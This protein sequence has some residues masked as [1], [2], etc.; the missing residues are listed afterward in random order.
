MSQFEIDIQCEVEVEPSL[1]L[2]ARKAAQKTLTH[3]DAKKSTSLTLLL[4][5]NKRLQQLN[6]DFL[7][8]DYPT[9]VLSFPSGESWNGTENYLGDIAISISKAEA[10]AREAGHDLIGELCL[11]VVHGVL[12]LLDYDHA[13][14]G[15]AQQMG[16]IQ[17][18]ILSQL[19]LAD[20]SRLNS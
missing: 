20:A 16:R 6:S 7:G 2:A 5:D 12:H 10:Q 9:D 19:G 3:E 14:D 8:N 18:E 15:E 17:A 4:A 11:L 13:T 1:V